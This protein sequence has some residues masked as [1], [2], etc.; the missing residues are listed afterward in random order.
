MSILRNLPGQYA[1]WQRLDHVLELRLLLRR[2]ALDAVVAPL[3]M[4]SRRLRRHG[5]GVGRGR[6][7]RVVAAHAVLA[8]QRALAANLVLNYIKE[9]C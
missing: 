3:R 2:L 4:R 6:G 8:L 9:S 5:G 7:R 1:G